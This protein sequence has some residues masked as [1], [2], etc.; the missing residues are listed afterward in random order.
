MT[1]PELTNE[2]PSE[3]E[4]AFQEA[5]AG[6]EVFGEGLHAYSPSRRVAAQTMGLLYP[7]VGETG[8]DQFDKT[9][10]YPGM[11]KDVIILLWLCILPDPSELTVA[12][13][14]EKAWTPSRALQKPSDAM[15]V[16]MT[17]A[18][19]KGVCDMASPPYKEASEVFMAI[20][21][22]VSASEFRLAIA[23]MESA[24]GDPP[25]ETASPNV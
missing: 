20:V 25:T 8:S 5:K 23:E 12:Q 16:A 3:A 7:Y 19:E 18:E 9:G 21:A 11:L 4:V 14:K 10:T 15:E 22:G 17:W 1:D 6:F 24:P 2:Q 13:V